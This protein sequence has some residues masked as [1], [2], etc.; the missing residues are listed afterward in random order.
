MTEWRPLPLGSSLNGAPSA[1]APAPVIGKLEILPF[2][3]LSWEDFERLQWRVMH[4]VEGLRHAQI[5]GDRGQAQYGLDIVALAPDGIG[6]ALQSKKYTKFGA[7]EI[8]A[9]VKKFRTTERPFLVDRLIIG[10]ASTVR[11]TGAMEELCEQSKTLQPI[12]LEL[13]DAQRLSYLLRGRPEIVIEFFGM[14]T[15]EAFCLPFKLNV[16]SVPA[17]EVVAI[18]EAI[19][20]TPEVATGAQQYFDDAV[21]T[22]DPGQALLLIEAGQAKLRDAGFGPHAAQ[23]DKDRIRLLASVGRAG[24]A[25]RYVLDDFWAAL[26]QG[27]SATARITQS[28]LEE[29]SKLAEQNEQVELYRRVGKVAIGLYLNP[30]AYVP[31]VGSLRIGD[32][33]D[34]VRLALLAGE[35]ALSN[36]D[37]YWLSRAVPV[38]TELS[39][40]SS[41]DRV[42]RTR[43]R[44]IL[45]EATGDWSELLTDARRLQLGHDLL[46]LVTARYAR[47]CALREKFQEAD[48][49]W[50]E[51]SGYATLARQWGEAS[52]WIF[53][54]RGFRTH[55]N[56]FT[57]DDLLPLQTAIRGMGTS[58]PIVPAADGAYED[59][60]AALSDQKLRS[61]A[62]SAQRALRDAVTVGDWVGEERARRALATIL[63]ESDEPALAARHLARAGA[64]KAIEALGKALPREFIDVLDDLA[65]PNYWTV[66]TVYRLLATQADLI[67]DDFVDTVSDHL[68][69]ELA[70]AETGS[71]PDL[72]AFATSRYNNAV[73]A[74]AG[75]ADR[76]DADHANKA[77]SHFEKQPPV[78]ENHYRYH[79]EDEALVLAKIAITHPSLAARAV[80]HLAS[81][82]GRSQG[83]RNS[84]TLDAIDKNRQLAHETL[85]ALAGAGN[86]WASETLSFEDPKEFNA[87]VTAEAL[88]RLTTPLIHTDGVYSV[89]TNAI[90]DSLLVRHLPSDAVEAVVAE[91]LVRADD[92]YLSSSDRG[93]YLVAAANLSRHID[94]SEREEFFD[95]A[96]R[97]A[98]S[99]TP[100]EHDKFNE[101]F[102]HKLGGFRMNGTP[103]DS[104]GQAVLLAAA[105]AEDDNQRACVRRLAYSLLGEESDYWP[106]RA[107]QYLGDTIKD[108][109]AFLASQGWAIRSLAATLWVNFADP[110]HLGNRLAAD[111][112]VRVRRA[113]AHALAQQPETTHPTVRGQLATDPAY[114]VRVALRG[115]LI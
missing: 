106:T 22:S 57:S 6:V 105:F 34:Q 35:T 88:A 40:I 67:P 97:L 65:A 46:G 63:I 39:G 54:R 23:Y 47:H 50:E 36:D 89:G 69:G 11:R 61:A 12:S 110:A 28:R 43:S 20:R 14:P 85:T 102:T 18:R 91:L 41:I 111:H 33:A 80:P 5:Y 78:E 92:P 42:L 81:L 15:A 60:L 99:P 71:R 19:A 114:S 7:V 53:S 95:T 48:L 3:A 37:Q 98:T 32:S 44:L 59:A 13:W 45:A 82:L 86:R 76:L 64:I 9:A 49:A 17:A 70:A 24:E 104:R 94:Q 62:I 25:A 113:L 56:P 55:W 2:T 16:P 51:A 29:L 66:G 93:E 1:P 74:L 112:D 115:R 77:L 72:R 103:R 38:F 109:L 79:D 75:I 73:K 100:S 10:V 52:T 27:L 83:A 4:D 107:L 84:T 96:V 58:S 108:D 87:S 68:L 90:S 31:D 30:V 21:T 101:Q 8:R 26:D